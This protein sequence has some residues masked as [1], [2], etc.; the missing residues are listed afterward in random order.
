MLRDHMLA[1][2]FAYAESRRRR[3]RR[4]KKQRDDDADEEDASSSSSSDMNAQLDPV[5]A[6]IYDWFKKTAL[7]LHPTH[8]PILAAAV[9]AHAKLAGMVYNLLV[10]FQVSED[11]IAKAIRYGV[12]GA[13]DKK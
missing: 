12:P 2:D 13:A 3:R 5:S 8:D 4:S 7:D 11:V 9:E 10:N 1:A 6:T